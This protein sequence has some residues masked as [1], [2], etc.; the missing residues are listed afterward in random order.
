MGAIST[1]HTAGCKDFV[2][3]G[4]TPIAR[5]IPAIQGAKKKLTRT[6]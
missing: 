5:N 3:T 4:G 1:H 6:G 2:M